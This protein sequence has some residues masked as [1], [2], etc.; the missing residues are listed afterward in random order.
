MENRLPQ[1]SPSIAFGPGGFV[2][3]VSYAPSSSKHRRT[4]ARP[5][6]RPDSAASSS[7]ILSMAPP[8]FTPDV[9]LSSPA[10]AADD[11]ND[12]VPVVTDGG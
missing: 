6:A 12:A 7:A 10:A 4:M 3:N 1:A 11:P 2:Q 9:P 8:A 5:D